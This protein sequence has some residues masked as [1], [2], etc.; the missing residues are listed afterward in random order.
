MA[1][2]V[3]ETNIVHGWRA[4]TPTIHSYLINLSW[5]Q[6]GAWMSSGMLQ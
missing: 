6:A 5:S 2:A 3:K 1:S 4:V